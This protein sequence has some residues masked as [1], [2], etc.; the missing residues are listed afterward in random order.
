MTNTIPTNHAWFSY[1]RRKPQARI[2]LF[3]FPYAGG[4]ASV[5]R[6]WS[7]LMPR[8]I[9]VCPVQL[10]GR[11]NRLGE[12]AFSSLPP[13]IE[14]LADRMSPYLEMPYALFGHSMGSLVCFELARYLRRTAPASEPVALF[15]SG[16]RAPQLPASSPPI[17]NLPEPAF[18]E[19]LRH[20]QGTPEEVLQNEELL[21]L[22]MPLL[23][24]DFTLCENY[25]YYHEPP[26]NCPLSAFGGLQDTEVGIKTISAWREQTRSNFKQHFFPGGHF[27]LHK[28][29]VA[30]VR[31]L[32][33]DLAAI[34]E[35]RA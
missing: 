5:F 18:I 22:L 12:P 19:R 13:L 14:K 7:E 9:E 35:G 24:A 3:C 21:H 1:W 23:R 17:C 4:A 25:T 27:F 32:V 15:V 2:R 30:L 8:E 29:Q 28:E 16:H 11:E 33:Q 6:T 10:P 34:R 20:L 26:L 31:T